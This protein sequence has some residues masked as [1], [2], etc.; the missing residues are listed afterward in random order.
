MGAVRCDRPGPRVRQ[1][2][3][4]SFPSPL[5]ISSFWPQRLQEIDDLPPEW[6]EDACVNGEPAVG[7]WPDG[8]IVCY[9]D[10]GVAKIRWTDYR[11]GLY[12]IVDATNRDLP[13]LVTWWRSN[14][15]RLGVADWAG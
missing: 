5:H 11:S 3:I 8:D 6:G 2:A 13:A 14:A 12:G 10:D 9:I 1:L 15:Q 4:Y 7:T